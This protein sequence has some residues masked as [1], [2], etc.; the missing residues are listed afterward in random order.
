M[1]KRAALRTMA[2]LVFLTAVWIP[3]PGQQAEAALSGDFSYMDNGDGTA[4]ITSYMGTNTDVI[5]PSALDGL[6]VTGIGQAAFFSDNLTSVVIPNTVTSIGKS[7]FTNNRLTSLIIPD[8]VTTI[9]DQAFMYN[10]LTSLA[11]PDS[12]TTIGDYAF[13][14]NNLTSLT[15]SNGLKSILRA[16]FFRKAWST[17]G[18]LFSI[19]TI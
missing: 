4:A 6:T 14:I 17:W 1:L 7:A 2:L 15:L 8:S 16:S 19:G 5:I 3:V 9:G 13:R 10:Q 18:I 11:I 12:V